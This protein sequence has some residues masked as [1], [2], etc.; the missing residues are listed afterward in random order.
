MASSFSFLRDQV[1]SDFLREDFQQVLP[2][3][4]CDDSF[5]FL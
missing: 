1:K 5:Y 2:V 4:F 3:I